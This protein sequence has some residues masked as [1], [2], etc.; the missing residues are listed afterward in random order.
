MISDV[1][2]NLVPL[3]SRQPARA[4]HE[5]TKTQMSL[6]LTKRSSSSGLIASF[7]PDH[8]HSK[9]NSRGKS[10]DG[11][12]ATLSAV[13]MKELLENAKRMVERM[14][15]LMEQDLGEIAFKFYIPSEGK[16]Y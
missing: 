12:V 4:R 16:L 3:A 9:A 5:T 1:I 6:R 10:A 8:N 11:D 2:P 13:Q 14:R 15:I 7:D